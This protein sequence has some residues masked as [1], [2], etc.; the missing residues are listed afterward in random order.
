MYVHRMDGTSSA[1]LVKEIAKGGWGGELTCRECGKLSPHAAFQIHMDALDGE[2]VVEL[3][4]FQ[5][6]STR[7]AR[8]RAR[9]SAGCVGFDRAKSHD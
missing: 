4:S 3:L 6:D 2:C 5:P 1:D 8:A 9:I 7:P